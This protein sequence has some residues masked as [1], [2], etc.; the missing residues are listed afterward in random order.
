MPYSINITGISGGTA[1]ISFYVCDQNANNCEFLGYAVGTYVLPTFY[2]DAETLV[3]KAVDNNGCIF[4]RVISC[5]IDDCVI[6][7]ESGDFLTTEDGFVLVFC[8]W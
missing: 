6:L 2:Q 7:S 3:I 5:L 1:P 8:D 4:L